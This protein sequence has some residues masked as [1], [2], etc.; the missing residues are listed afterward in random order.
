MNETERWAWLG[1]L[2][3]G[4]GSFYAY[5]W[6][7]PKNKTGYS[8]KTIFNVS[9]TNMS[10]LSE[11]MRIT[12]CGRLDK[13]HHAGG[14]GNRKPAWLVQ[15][16]RQEILQIVPRLLPY[17]VGKRKQA[18]ILLEMARRMPGRHVRYTQEDWNYLV[19]LYNELRALN[20]RGLGSF[21]PISVNTVRPSIFQTRS[22]NCSVSGCTRKLKACGF[23][24]PHYESNK[25]ILKSQSALQV[26]TPEPQAQAQTG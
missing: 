12:G 14:N 1:G 17:L 11:V 15:F 2:I 18:E 25:R 6:R 4:E 23:C 5:L 26:I 21:K 8:M 20:H 7:L 24:R 16:G 10:L 19:S 22:P 9:N 13:Q 3:D